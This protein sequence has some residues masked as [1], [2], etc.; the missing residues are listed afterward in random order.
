MATLGQET[1]RRCFISYH[2]EDEQEVKEFINRFDHSHDVFISRGIGA[3]MAGDIINSSDSDYIKRRIREQ[4]LRGSTVTIVMIGR[5]TWA[6]KFVDW[7]IAASLRNNPTSGRSGLMAITLPSVANYTGR[8]LPPR[9]E[10]NLDGEQGYARWWQYPSSVSALARC[11]EVAY[12]NRQNTLMTVRN[13]LPL[14][15]Y[16]RTCS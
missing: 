8:K 16:N 4:Y 3:G 15:S 14:Y 9:L 6:R 11:I 1:R 13:G 2:K 7:E 5:C 10:E 12:E